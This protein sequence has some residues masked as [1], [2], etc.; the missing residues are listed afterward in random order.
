MS[1]TP[2]LRSAWSDT[3]LNRSAYMTWTF[4][5]ISTGVF[6]F[7]IERC[8]TIMLSTAIDYLGE[9]EDGP[10]LVVFCLFG[11]AAYDVFAAE[12]DRQSKNVG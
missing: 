10:G 11:Q 3:E 1:I 2:K 7:P 4:P 5:A 12:L 8:A 6:G 9:A